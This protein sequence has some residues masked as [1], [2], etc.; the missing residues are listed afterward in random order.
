MKSRLLLLFLLAAA[1]PAT[2]QA[3]PELTLDA[4]VRQA[5]HQHP[6]LELAQANVARAASGVR[7]AQSSRLPT[8]NLDA[9]LTRFQE[10]MV[11]APLHG[12]DLQ[13]PPKFDRTLS[14]GTASLGYTLFDASRGA[15]VE[16]AEALED[17]AQS[18]S[19]AARMQVLAD[20]TRAFLRAR[21]AREVAEAHER[22]S[23]ALR[24]ERDRA[25][26]LVEQGRAA[27]VVLLRA[28]AALSAAI[29]DGV[30]AQ[31]DVNV[32]ANELAR[33][34]NVSPD[35]VR[36]AQLSGVRPVSTQMP[37]VSALRE[38]A[39]EHNPDLIRAQRQVAVAEATRGEAR[40]LRLPKLQLGGRYIEYASNTTD[41]Q[42]EWQGSVQLSY[43][44]FTGGA[45]AA[46]H[47]RANAEIQ[48]AVAEY[49]LAGRRVDDA[50]D[51][52]AAARSAAHARV[53]AL[54]AAVA[55]S[56]EV[57]RID[58]LALDAGAGVQSDYLTAQADL[59]RSRAAL[60]D[61]RAQEV[62]ALIELAR[63]SGQLSESWIAQNVE[64]YR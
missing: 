28:E 14:Q 42:G 60:T 59:F 32:A 9:N 22:R 43:P 54:E 17:A 34:L 61:A 37:S 11:V 31:S 39:R 3:P 7:E 36:S 4:A 16:R 21:T 1:A 47:D 15:R 35:S 48:A 30:G 8:L 55:Q 19:V 41:P 40:G 51:R 6:A 50:I 24:E 62:M 45:R 2:A 18:G 10:P 5:L 20:V 56:E 63:A 12:L 64:S 26:Q 57:T 53:S 38:I 23:A 49:D 33:Q 25:A 58:R 52:A 46:A 27:R 44:I 13:N 29:A